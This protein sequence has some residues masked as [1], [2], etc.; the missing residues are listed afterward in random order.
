MSSEPDYELLY[1]KWFFWIPLVMM[2]IVF[3]KAY[4]E[5]LE[6]GFINNVSLLIWFFIGVN[7]VLLICS[8]LIMKR[9]VHKVCGILMAA[10]SMIFIISSDFDF[11]EFKDFWYL[12]LS[13]IAGLLLFIFS[14]FDYSDDSDYSE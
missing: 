4:G 7:S 3:Y 14:F 6:Y 10:F 5:L 11:S 9:R 8:Y 2:G 12:Y 13:V 1:K